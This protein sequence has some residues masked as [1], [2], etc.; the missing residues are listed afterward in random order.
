MSSALDIL[1]LQIEELIGY[2]IE[3]YSNVGATI[4]VGPDLGGLTDDE[5]FLLTNSKTAGAVFRQVF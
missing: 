2:P 1:A 4:N 3:G 5:Y